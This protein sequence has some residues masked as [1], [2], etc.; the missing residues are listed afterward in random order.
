MKI[1]FRVLLTTLG[2]LLAAK[3]VPGI[4]VEGFWN[5]FFGSIV[6]SI[7]SWVLSAFFKG[8]DGEYHVITHHG[9]I[10]GSGEKPV[11]GKVIE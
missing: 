3:I 6:V 8:T 9:Q 1:L 7:V 10:Q 2:V 5:A 11:E 4:Y